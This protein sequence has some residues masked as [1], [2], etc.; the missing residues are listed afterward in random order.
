MG[1]D[2]LD[3][4]SYDELRALSAEL[5]LTRVTLKERMRGVNQSAPSRKQARMAAKLEVARVE[6]K[7][8]TKRVNDEIAVRDAA[9]TDAISEAGRVLGP[10]SIESGEEMGQL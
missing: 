5:E 2:R 7:A 8:A 4:L 1:T 6:V 3:L 10:S 9:A